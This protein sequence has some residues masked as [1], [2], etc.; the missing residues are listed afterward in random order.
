MHVHDLFGVIPFFPLKLF[1]HMFFIHYDLVK[2]CFAVYMLLYGNM[3][4]QIDSCLQVSLPRFF[5][6]FFLHCKDNWRKR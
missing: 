4:K 1:G 5:C 3:T 6:F 2:S